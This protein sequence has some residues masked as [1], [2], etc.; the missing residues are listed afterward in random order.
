M[1]AKACTSAESVLGTDAADAETWSVRCNARRGEMD[2]PINCVTYAQAEAFCKW[3]GKRLPRESEWELAARGP[4]GN[5]YVW[6][7]AEPSCDKAWY[8]R[9]GSCLN[10]AMEV[11]T[12]SVG[13]IA[14]DRNGQLA[15]DLAGNVSEWVVS[16]G[17]ERVTK[18]GNFNAEPQELAAALRSLRASGFAHVTVGFRCVESL[19]K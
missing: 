7:D 5:K 16:G 14:D 8:D 10:A 19:H 4:K 9:N 11:A 12:T 17:S 2:H 13:V 6:G 3:D 1:N 15:Y 18:G